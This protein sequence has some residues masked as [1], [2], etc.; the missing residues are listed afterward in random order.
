MR[1]TQ[2]VQPANIGQLQK[3]YDEIVDYLRHWDRNMFPIV[4]HI[5]AC[6][7]EFEKAMI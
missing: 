4:G 7:T 1:S 6:L 5:G 3:R 2:G